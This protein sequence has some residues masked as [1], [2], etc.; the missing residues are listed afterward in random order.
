VLLPPL[1]LP[2][3]LL[4]PLLLPPLPPLLLPPLLL[5]PLLA[6]LASPGI[7]APLLA[8]PP[9]LLPP[10]PL[11]SLLLPLLPVPTMFDPL[12]LLLDPILPGLIEP[13]PASNATNPL[14]SLQAAKVRQH[15]RSDA[16]AGLIFSPAV[17]SIYPKSLV[18]TSDAARS[19]P[20]SVA[21]RTPCGENLVDAL[22]LLSHECD[23]PLGVEV[24]GYRPTACLGFATPIST[25]SSLNSA[26]ICS[27]PPSALM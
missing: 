20:S 21:S 13:I 22:T 16:G 2:P 23:F 19:L 26:R 7:A 6:T 10:L 15:E 9:L 4:P 27:S 24:L 1:L 11:V 12:P 25:D 18:A 14:P 3:L 8:A 17:S 5:P